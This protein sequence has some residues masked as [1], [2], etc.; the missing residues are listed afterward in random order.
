MLTALAFPFLGSILLSKDTFW[1]SLRE[2]IPDRS[3]SEIWTKT[4]GPPP[5][6]SMKPK[7]FCMLKNFTVPVGIVAPH[8]VAAASLL[9]QSYHDRRRSAL[10]FHEPHGR[11]V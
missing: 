4:S 2:C 10:A 7:P 9:N 3:T 11:K 8:F 5:S 6:T 1:P